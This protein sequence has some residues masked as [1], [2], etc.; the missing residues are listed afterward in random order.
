[1]IIFDY[2]GR[3]KARRTIGEGLLQK[4]LKD[5][6]NTWWHNCILGDGSWLDNAVAALDGP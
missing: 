1:M 4:G 5:K 2:R 3:E 6:M